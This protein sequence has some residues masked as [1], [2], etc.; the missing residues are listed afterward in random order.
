MYPKRE[1]SFEPEMDLPSFHNKIQRYRFYISNH[2]RYD[3]YSAHIKGSFPCMIFFTISPA[4]H[5]NRTGAF[6]YSRSSL[7]HTRTFYFKTLKLDVSIGN[8]GSGNAWSI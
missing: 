1:S 8:E 7:H 3:S 4:I 5:V 2:I 6:K